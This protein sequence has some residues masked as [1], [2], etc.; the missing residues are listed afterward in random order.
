L[1]I[2][3]WTR[4][5]FP[6]S[7]QK[8]IIKTPY[9]NQIRAKEVRVINSD[10]SQIG[11]FPV[12]EAI[13][14]A[15]DKGMDLV[16]ITEKAVPPVCKIIDYGK[17]L[18][19]EKKKEKEKKVKNSSGDI[20]GIRLKFAMSPHDMEIRA[21]SASAFLKKGYKVR[22]E[23]ILKGRQK[24]QNLSEFAKNKIDL[25]LESVKKETPFKIE[26]ELKKEG[27]GLTIMISKL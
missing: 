19:W 21:K 9:N 20:K 3:L 22:I 13:K 5:Q 6:P 23:L 2:A 11:I 26:R 1:S 16:Q 7:P 8:T 27:K 4:V 14:L 25:F 10:G 12:S 17:F 18:Y 15:K 24:S